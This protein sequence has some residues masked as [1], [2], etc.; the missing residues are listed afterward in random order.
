M[1]PMAEASTMM[2]RTLPPADADEREPRGDYCQVSH[3]AVW[4]GLLIVGA[5]VMVLLGWAWDISWLKNVLPGFVTMKAN[6]AA[7][8]VLTG[9]SLACWG[10]AGRS[11]GLRF[12]ALGC[13]GATMG[14]GIVTLCE[15]MVGMDLGIDLW[16]F[17]EAPGSVGT[18]APGR[19][20]PVSARN[21]CPSHW[22]KP[23]AASS[24]RMSC[25]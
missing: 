16:M 10:R 23:T 7:G 2:D 21:R 4:L 13:A 12:V 17:Q 25:L 5:G 8:F 14:L 3:K 15:Y 22:H 6:T 20:A 24:P 19:M 18:L 11:Q 1:G 9:V